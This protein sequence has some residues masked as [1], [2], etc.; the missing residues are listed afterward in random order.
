V[1]DALSRRDTETTTE[2]AAISAPSFAVLDEHRQ[3]HATDPALQAV[4][5]QVLDNE[6]GEH[7]RIIDSLIMAH[8]KVYVPPESPTLV[9]LLA[10]AHSCGHEGTEKTLHRLCV[11]FHVPDARDFMRNFVCACT[12][13]QRKKNRSATSGRFAPTAVGAVDGVGGHRDRLH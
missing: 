11:D 7:W 2:L 12:T 5:K 3:A 8:G 9:G 10:H 6:K 13:C 1:A 4:M